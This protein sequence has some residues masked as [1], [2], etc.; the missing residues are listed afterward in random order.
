MSCPKCGGTMVGDGYTMLRHCEFARPEDLEGKEADAGPVY[1]VTLD[2]GLSDTS[3]KVLSRFET[4]ETRLAQMGDTLRELIA[5]LG[6]CGSFDKH[7][8]C[9]NHFATRPCPVGEADLLLSKMRET[10]PEHEKNLVSF[11]TITEDKLK[12]AAI[13]IIRTYP[14]EIMHYEKEEVNRLLNKMPKG[15]VMVFMEPN[16]TLE[17]VSEN[18]M[19]KLGWV[20]VQ[21][22]N[23]E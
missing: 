5:A 15:G 22:E 10:E 4:V 17:T 1:C 13:L 6:P 20:K 14:C 23:H 19:K 3:K 9:G 8:N 11:D 2:S 18:E 21:G 16:Q 7:G 12:D